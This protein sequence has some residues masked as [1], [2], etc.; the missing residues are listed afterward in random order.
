[1]TEFLVALVAGL[2]VIVWWQAS[3]RAREHAATYVE[4]ACREAG[5][6]WLDSTVVF[7][8]LELARNRDGSRH[9]RRTYVFEYCD[10]GVSRRQGFIALRGAELEWVGFGPTGMDAAS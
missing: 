9:L 10:D 6:Q 7:R 8:R 3:T 2:A 5:V 4:Q 1:M